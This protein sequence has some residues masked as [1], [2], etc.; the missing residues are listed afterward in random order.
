M[1]PLDIVGSASGAEA[2]ARRCVAGMFIGGELGTADPA[3]AVRDLPPRA[4]N[5]LSS[6][7]WAMTTRLD[8][9]ALLTRLASGRP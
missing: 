5:V 7:L 8:D 4:V 1:S 3:E 6:M 2:L 9:V